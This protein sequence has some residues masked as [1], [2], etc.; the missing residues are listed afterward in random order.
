M[1]RLYSGPADQSTSLPSI[2]FALRFSWRISPAWMIVKLMRYM[3]NVS[4]RLQ[5]KSITGQNLSQE[6]AIAGPGA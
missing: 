5:D 2:D 6:K 1:G 4:N 3:L